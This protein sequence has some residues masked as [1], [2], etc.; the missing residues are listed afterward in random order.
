MARK[1]PFGTKVELKSLCRA[2]GLTV[3]GLRDDLEWRLIWW[4]ECR[5][6]EEI[7]IALQQ[8]PHL[9]RFVPY[10]WHTVAV[11]DLQVGSYCHPGYCTNTVMKLEKVGRLVKITWAL[12]GNTVTYKTGDK[13]SVGLSHLLKQDA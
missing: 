13:I 9:C 7:K 8:H 2:L 1:S 12:H 4:L 6:I 10:V 11:E 3:G 5:P